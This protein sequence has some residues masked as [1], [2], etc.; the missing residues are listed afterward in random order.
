MTWD[1]LRSRVRALFFRRRM[2][3][4]L[5]EEMAAHL[6]AQTRKYMAQGLSTEEARRRACVDFGALEGAKE[7]C[8]D[9][10]GISWLTNLAQDLRFALRIVR[11]AP[12][13]TGLIV[14]V[15]GLGMEPTS[16]PSA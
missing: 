9:T 2:E 4:E 8:R 10:R 15:L 5:Q 7:E 12:A 16:P 1:D 6:E 11:R 3:A 13:F 14:L